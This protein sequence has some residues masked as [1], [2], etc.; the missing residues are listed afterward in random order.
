MKNRMCKK[1]ASDFVRLILGEALEGQSDMAIVINLPIEG[2]NLELPGVASFL[3]VM[4]PKF[5]YLIFG[6]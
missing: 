5:N 3:P 1:F 4:Q 2:A 6:N